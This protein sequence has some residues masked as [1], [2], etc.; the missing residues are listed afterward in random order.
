M[1]KI[2]GKSTESSSMRMLVDHRLI[3]MSQ[4]IIDARVSV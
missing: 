2:T 1:C 4:L 3:S